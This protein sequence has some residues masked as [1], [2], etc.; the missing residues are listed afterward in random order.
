MSKPFPMNRSEEV[1]VHYVPME[2][3]FNI[4]FE[5]LLRGREI[6]VGEFHN[7]YVLECFQ[8]L[9]IGLVEFAQ[10]QEWVESY[11]DLPRTRADSASKQKAQPKQPV[12]PTP[13][14]K[15]TLKRFDVSLVN[16]QLNK[17]VVT[18]NSGTHTVTGPA[19]QQLNQSAGKIIHQAYDALTKSTVA[20]PP[21]PM[22]ELDKSSH[23]VKNA[24]RDL[25]LAD[26]RPF[27]AKAKD[28]L[29]L[30][31]A[32]ALFSR[33]QKDMSREL[34]EDAE[35]AHEQEKRAL[36][37]EAI[38]KEFIKQEI[39]EEQVNETYEKIMLLSAELGWEE[40]DE[41]QESIEVQTK[42]YREFLRLLFAL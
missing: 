32:V 6:R 33:S 34:A 38:K 22:P 8:Q 41:Q 37:K 19:L 15:R 10:T 28:L 11:E 40:V 16:G 35:K 23:V 17:L 12:Q 4:T 29:S 5:G 1:T 9:G 39:T 7:P 27:D 20:A 18:T 24:I 14:K 31:N 36:K 21:V 42:H 26:A 25:P 3:L 30:L 2:D 13:S